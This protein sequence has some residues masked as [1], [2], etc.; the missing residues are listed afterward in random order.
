MAD[1]KFKYGTNDLDQVNYEAGSVYVKKTSSKKAQM[2][3]DNPASRERLQI[4]GEIFVGDPSDKDTSDYD[5]II[6]PN[7][8]VIEDW[9]TS[10]V[11]GGFVIRVEE[12]AENQL[13]TYTP[14]DNPN[15]N[16]ITFVLKK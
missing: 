9:V 10:E 12:I 14:Q 13:D 15:K 8:N 4:G 6:N 1:L 2:F 3:I 7:G 16:M 11:V 5:V